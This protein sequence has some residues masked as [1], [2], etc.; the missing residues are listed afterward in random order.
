MVFE[1]LQYSIHA[2]MPEADGEYGRPQ[3]Y[4]NGDLLSSRCGISG[5]LKRI[6]ERRYRQIN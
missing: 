1:A 4:V 2:A 3:E 5:I 6:I